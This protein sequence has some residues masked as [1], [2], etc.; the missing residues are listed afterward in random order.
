[1]PDLIRTSVTAPSSLFICECKD[2][3]VGHEESH[4]YIQR[5]LWVSDQESSL[6]TGQIK[7]WN[8]Q[9]LKGI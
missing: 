5:V 7:S 8:L 1:M 6:L 2:L 9:T 3:A 4:F